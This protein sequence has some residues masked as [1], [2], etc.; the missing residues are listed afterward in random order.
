MV[1]GRPLLNLQIVVDGGDKA[2]DV[3]RLDDDVVI[4]QV[5]GEYNLL[6]V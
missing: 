5:A 6:A 2:D 1:R 4:A 3:V